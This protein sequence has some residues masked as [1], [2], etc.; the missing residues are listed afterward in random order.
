MCVISTEITAVRDLPPLSRKLFKNITVK[1][2]KR[3]L[4]SGEHPVSVMLINA[5]YSR[6]G[7]IK[8]FKASPPK[9]HA[10]MVNPS[11]FRVDEVLILAA[12]L[13]VNAVRLAAWFMGYDWDSLNGWSDEFEEMRKTAR[14]KRG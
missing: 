8:L 6:L 7:L 3:I 5:G 14:G 10:L 1:K 11:M 4:Y 12:L 2:R 13:E 9:W